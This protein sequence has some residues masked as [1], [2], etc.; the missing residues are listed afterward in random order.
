MSIKIIGIALLLASATISG[1]IFKSYKNEMKQ[2]YTD[3]EKT[4]SAILETSYGKVEYLCQGKGIPVLV[5]HGMAGGFDQALQTG[6]GLLGEGYKIIAVSRFGYLN[7]NLPKESTPEDQAKAYK[8]LLDYLGI[9]KTVILAVSAG[10]APA[11]QF[12]LKYPEKTRVLI[13]I[14]S[15]APAKKEI[16]GPTGPPHFV[17]NDFVFWVMLKYMKHKMLSMMF[18]ISKEMY[19]NA[20]LKEKQRVDELLK[21]ILP[22]EPRKPGMINDE[23]ITN[24]D[25]IVN[26]NDYDLENLRVPTL[27]IH[28]KDDP[29]AS[30]EDAK[31][32]AGRIPNSEFVAFDDGGHLIFGHS[33]EVQ[34]IINKFIQVRCKVYERDD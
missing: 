26:Y 19:N 27:I 1:F 12:A 23:K 11:L 30:F 16:K 28:A 29:L 4:N 31:N 6:V 14:G 5:V 20:S 9:D 32:M 18:G 22:I 17:I 8:E 10:G 25:M 13:L 3:I 15:G 24:L 34:K 21:T 7:S 2:F 33:E